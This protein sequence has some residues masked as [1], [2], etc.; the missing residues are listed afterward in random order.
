LESNDYAKVS[1]FSVNFYSAQKFLVAHTAL[2]TLKLTI[3]SSTDCS[4]LVK[5]WCHLYPIPSTYIVASMCH[6]A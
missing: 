2:A 6:F 5:N 3:H 1:T 4:L